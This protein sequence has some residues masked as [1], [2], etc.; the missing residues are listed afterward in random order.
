[1]EA[2]VRR[3]A[4]AAVEAALRPCAHRVCARALDRPTNTAVLGAG[5]RGRAWAGAL[6][7]LLDAVVALLAVHDV[8]VAASGADVAVLGDVLARLALVRPGRPRRRPRGWRRRWRGAWRRRLRNGITFRAIIAL[9]LR[10][11]VKLRRRRGAGGAIAAALCT[12]AHRARLVRARDRGPES[13][14][15]R[16]RWRCGNPRRY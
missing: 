1:M 7:L 10:A 12:S 2:V 4:D 9:G 5:G 16:R 11:A 13:T 8:V 14:G 3:G 15:R 6:A